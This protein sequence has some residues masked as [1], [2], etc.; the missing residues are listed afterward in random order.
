MESDVN[1]KTITITTLGGGIYLQMNDDDR[2]SRNV[3]FSPAQPSQLISSITNY[4]G[5]NKQPYI[6]F[7]EVSISI[8][9][10]RWLLQ[11]TSCKTAEDE[12]RRMTIIDSL[13]RYDYLLKRRFPIV[14]KFDK[15]EIQVLS[16]V[17]STT[18]FEPGEMMLL[19]S[20]VED[21]LKFE[22]VEEQGVDS[23]VLLQKVER[24]N[25]IERLHLVDALQRYRRSGVSG[26]EALVQAGLVS[27]PD[28]EADE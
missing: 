24:L 22:N 1:Q 17:I 5:L 21:Y 4:F 14:D 26:R 25:E 20:E 3:I 23:R 16:D 11:N 7:T 9:E 10:V 15:D 12:S 27:E 6:E 13:H 19:I 8:E 18:R 28:N 2:E